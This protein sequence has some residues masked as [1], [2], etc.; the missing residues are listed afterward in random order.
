MHFKF[1][2]TNCKDCRKEMYFEL[3][4]SGEE[5]EA[6]IT[7][8]GRLARKLFLEARTATLDH[9]LELEAGGFDMVTNWQL[10]CRFCNTTKGGAAAYGGIT[11]EYWLDS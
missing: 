2:V 1:G 10:L 7:D 9:I 6:R 3:F 11:L 8:R 4:E 5:F